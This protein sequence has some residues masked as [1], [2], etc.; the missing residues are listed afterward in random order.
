MM[1]KGRNFLKKCVQKEVPHK[2][3][4]R[5]LEEEWAE[6]VDGNMENFL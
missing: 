1:K 3:F 4:I 2:G 5:G 6:E